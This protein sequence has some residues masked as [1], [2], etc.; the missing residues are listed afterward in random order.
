MPGQTEEGHRR[1]IEV[2]DELTADERLLLEF[3]MTLPQSPIR[4][5]L[6]VSNFAEYSPRTEF[7]ALRLTSLFTSVN[8]GPP[9]G[10]VVACTLAGRLGMT[11]VTRQPASELLETLKDSLLAAS[12]TLTNDNAPR[13]V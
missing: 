2:M 8:G 10:T 3:V 7:G 13:I 1:F 6:M 4:Y 5:E 11:L 12:R 9:I